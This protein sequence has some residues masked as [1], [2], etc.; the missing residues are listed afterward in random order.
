MADIL[1]NEKFAVLA[2]S[3]ARL[4]SVF[5]LAL[6]ISDDLVAV[7][8]L[9]LKVDDS[10]QEDLGRL[11]MRDIAD[12]NFSLLTK[13]LSD[14][15]DVMDDENEALA[16]R[17]REILLGIL[18]EGHL[19]YDRMFTF[20]GAREGTWLRISKFCHGWDYNMEKGSKPLNLCKTMLKAAL[21]NAK[22]LPRFYEEGKSTRLT[23]GFHAFEQGLKAESYEDRAR[24]FVR[25]VEALVLPDIGKTRQQFVC[26]CM[27]F[28]K[29]GK[30]RQ[31][32]EDIYDLRS[33]VEHMHGWDDIT[34]RV[35][36]PVKQRPRLLRQACVLARYCYKR[37]ARCTELIPIFSSDVAIRQF[38]NKPEAERGA[39]WGHRLALNSVP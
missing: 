37:L 25:A 23:R 31:T 22:G 17:L 16:K 27:T 39:I 21:E 34:E 26:R 14:R 15:P 9:P 2:L 20:G 6:R 8:G 38:W 35:T 10:W 29:G 32:L 19:K 36:M 5:P 7:R 28:A 13:K 18:L 11:N 24:D 4:S 3:G 12:C 33:L 1:P 30:A